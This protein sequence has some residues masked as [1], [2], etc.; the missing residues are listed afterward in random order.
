M[1]KKKFIQRHCIPKVPRSS[2]ARP[3]SAVVMTAPSSGGKTEKIR[4]PKL[5]C[6]LYLLLTLILD[7]YRFLL[8]SIDFFPQV[9]TLV[10][11][12]SSTNSHFR[13]F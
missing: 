10:L 11:I 13:L 3:S 12:V 1:V 5:L 6:L 4:V 7:F 9:K 8:T 2:L